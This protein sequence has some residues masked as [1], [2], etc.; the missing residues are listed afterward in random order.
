MTSG[1]APS[2]ENDSFW[3]KYDRLFII[4]C[5]KC[6][7]FDG[8]IQVVPYNNLL[9]QSKKQRLSMCDTCVAQKYSLVT[10]VKWMDQY[11]VAEK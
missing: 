5:P 3:E 11:N 10:N 9:T 8:D 6:Q 1:G 4:C 2:R 7:I